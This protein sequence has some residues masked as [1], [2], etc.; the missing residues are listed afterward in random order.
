MALT[1]HILIYPNTDS[2][3]WLVSCHFPVNDRTDRTL[4]PLFVADHIDQ[5]SPMKFMRTL[6]LIDIFLPRLP[7]LLF[8]V[9]GDLVVVQTNHAFLILHFTFAQDKLY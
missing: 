3:I 5:T 7:Q 9:L 1:S 2:P 4:D 8:D 6:Q